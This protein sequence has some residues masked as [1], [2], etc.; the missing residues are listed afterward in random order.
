MRACSTA[1]VPDKA[2][3]EVHPD[4]NAFPRGLGEEDPGDAFLETSPLLS[5]WHRPSYTMDQGSRPLKACCH[6]PDSLLLLQGTMKGV[7]KK[8]A[9]F[10]A[11]WQISLLPAACSSNNNLEVIICVH[12]MHRTQLLKTI[13]WKVCESMTHVRQGTSILHSQK[14]ANNPL[15]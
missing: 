3:Q 8:E 7:H 15:T 13:Y 6:P 9:A 10:T 1:D 14:R 4:N 2:C 11:C 5:P 12:T